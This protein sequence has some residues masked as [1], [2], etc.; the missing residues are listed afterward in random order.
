MNDPANG[1]DEELAES[2]SGSDDQAVT[3]LADRYG[4][5][6]YDFALRLTL[7]TEAAAE[8]LRA[9]FAHLRANAAD[10]PADMSLRAWLF[11]FALAQGLDVAADRDRS[12]GSRLSTGD[13][14]FTQTDPGI[15]REAALWAWQAARSLRPRDYAV[16]DLTSRRNLEPGELT[17]PA[18]EGRG[19]IDTILSRA[20][21][22]FAEAYVATALYFR[23]RDA[24]SELS[25]LVGGSGAAMRVG[26][27]RQIVSH[28]ED[29]ATCQATL[30]ALPGAT[31]V[32]IALH[33]VEV[34][35]ELPQQVLDSVA[36]AGVAA[37]AAG[38]L[39]LDDAGAAEEAPSEP[40]E[41]PQPEAEQ[42]EPEVTEA[43]TETPTEPPPEEPESQA[44]TL[45]EP[46]TE[47]EPSPS[48]SEE[49][50]WAPPEGAAE[51][52][53]AGVAAGELPEAV[54]EIEERL[55]VEPEAE[56]Q[57]Q[58]A[59]V[60]E[61]YGTE[62]T[63]EPTHYA[64]GYH[65]APLSMRERLTLWFEPAY[66]QSFVLAYAVLGAVT[67]AAVFL[68]LLIAGAF[69]GGI[70]DPVIGP[71][72]VRE[73]ACETGP[74][75]LDAGKSKTFAFDPSSLSGFVLDSVSVSDKPATATDNAL[76]VKTAGSTSI[77]ATAAAVAS[78]SAR[79]DQY[80]L[81]LLWQRGDEDA[82]TDCPMVVNVAAGAGPSPTPGTPAAEGTPEG[83]T[84]PEPTP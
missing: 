4:R 1:S 17:G 20:N 49:E 56:P 60:Y 15:D 33:D 38:Q 18:T 54:S 64:G 39:S 27:R 29:C 12:A 14:R 53:L 3:V 67:A 11:N 30:D 43:G 48:V 74:M 32:F 31:D 83:E 25:E 75:S 82:V 6:L 16:L 2:L 41:A 66:G 68:G 9:T 61:Q 81:Q 50:L 62:Y 55:G 69:G 46:A 79:S 57:Y 35:A 5:S 36:A 24:C 37:G 42:P 23:G 44:E 10:R 70:S 22:G 8:I 40:E 26:I 71:D 47:P 21:T 84:T 52:G 58:E 77:S 80:G 19:G 72:Q 13:R 63:Q 45:E 73:I 78:A 34:P 59:E 76:V 65:L 51:A 28:V 7:D